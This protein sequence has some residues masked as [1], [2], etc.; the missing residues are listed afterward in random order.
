MICQHVQAELSPSTQVHREGAIAEGSIKR[1][2]YG[3]TESE[4]VPLTEQQVTY[5]DGHSTLSMRKIGMASGYNQRFW[6]VI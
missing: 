5:C 2:G 1:L 4:L 6:N 3:T